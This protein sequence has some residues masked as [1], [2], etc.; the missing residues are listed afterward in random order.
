MK[1]T[2]FQWLI[3]SKFTFPIWVGLGLYFWFY[4]LGGDWNALT[5]DQQIAT[6][7]LGV[8]FAVPWLL[9]FPTVFF[10]EREQRLYAKSALSPEERWQKKMVRQTFFLVLVA[11]ALLYFGWQWWKSPA[12]E[13]QPASFKAAAAGTLGAGVLA[14]TAYLKVKSWR[15]GSEEDQPAIVSWCLPVPK[16]PTIQVIVLPDYCKRVM[17]AGGVRPQAASPPIQTEVKT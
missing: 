3:A 6:T 11:I 2:P 9:S 10:Y 7:I 16:Q 1:P 12:P 15:N 14:T 13:A 8:L 4:K 17:S 5:E